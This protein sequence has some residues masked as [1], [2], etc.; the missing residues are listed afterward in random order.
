MAGSVYDGH[1]IET[2]WEPF[3]VYLALFD[4]YAY[5][6]SAAGTKLS[7]LSSLDHY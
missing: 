3:V 4:L 1:D 6:S 5:L 2:Q 7:E